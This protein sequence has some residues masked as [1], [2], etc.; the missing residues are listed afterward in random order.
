MKTYG[1]KRKGLLS[2]FASFPDDRGRAGNQTKQGSYA[3]LS[4]SNEHDGNPR[5]V[6]E[7]HQEAE[8][9][10]EAMVNV[11]LDDTSQL[12][13][14]RGLLSADESTQHERP[15]KLKLN[16]HNK[17]LPPLPGTDPTKGRTGDREQA[18]SSAALTPKTTNSIVKLRATAQAKRPVQNPKASSKGYTSKSTAEQLALDPDRAFFEDRGI[19][20]ANPDGP[21]DV[22]S[23]AGAEALSKKIESLIATAGEE[24][25]RTQSKQV[26]AVNKRTDGKHPR[27]QRSR[28]VLAKVKGAITDR[29]TSSAKKENSKIRK[30]YLLSP[31]SKSIEVSDPASNHHDGESSTSH[32]ADAEGTNIG[33]RLD[34]EGQNLGS[35]KIRSL[36][37]VSIP[38]KPLPSQY[39]FQ[40]LSEG[41]SS[42]GDP[43]SDIH[44][45][46]DSTYARSTSRRRG[47]VSGLDRPTATRLGYMTTTHLPQDTE[48]Y[49]C[50]TGANDSE[51]SD[52]TKFSPDLSGLV[53]HPNPYEF[54]SSPVAH[55]TP[56]IQIDSY[57]D[58]SMAVT[59]L[60]SDDE[61]YDRIKGKKTSGSIKRQAN[62]KVVGNTLLAPPSKKV[63]K[64]KKPAVGSSQV[65]VKQDTG[66]SRHKSGIV[67]SK[68]GNRRIQGNPTQAVKGE[69][70]AVLDTGKPNKKV[71]SSNEAAE[72]PRERPLRRSAIPKPVRKS[73]ANER[74]AVSD[75][76]GVMDIDELQLDLSEY[77]IGRT[78]R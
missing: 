60:E 44:Q 61:P 24:T 55:S 20:P 43:F 7:M 50:E 76:S 63:K 46:R 54:S 28:E 15:R 26:R 38:R 35:R 37:G 5:P 18:S 14:D 4:S 72:I 48:R 34:A 70:Q 41:P 9:S 52:E 56:R 19:I 33:Q 21:R 32:D 73:A 42:G 13:Q 51:A 69:K 71:S 57:E 16:A 1:K 36:T 78:R 12:S 75:T 64:V 67:A 11:L 29:L 45:M 3:R 74:S 53:Q 39:N 49:S 27:L 65:T 59:Q 47:S 2:P 66:S 40:P 77:R 23:V 17:P 31:S 58:S 30:K 10:V 68:D 6:S 62:K 22:T 25:S 8:D